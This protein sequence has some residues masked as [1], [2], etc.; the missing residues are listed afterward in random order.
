MKRL[1]LYL[2]IPLLILTVSCNFDYGTW[3]D[4]DKNWQRAFNS[5]LSPSDS[6]NIIHS[7]YWRSPHFTFEHGFF[8]QLEHT[9]RVEKIFLSGKDLIKM[10]S[11]EYNT[12]H[13]FGDKPTWFVPEDY[14][15]YD[16]WKSS[17]YPNYFLFIDKKKKTISFAEFQ[18]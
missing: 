5:P 18:T 8:F 11:T 10:D 13:F 3:E 1:N 17:D 12:I 14:M 4:D 15:Y 6:F 2:L 9:A 7:H 16:I